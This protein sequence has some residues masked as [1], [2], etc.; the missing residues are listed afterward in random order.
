MRVHL[1]P[2]RIKPRVVPFPAW[3]CP[4]ITPALLIPPTAVLSAPGTL[5]VVN[6]KVNF[7]ALA[8]L[9]AI[10]NVSANPG[11]RNSNLQVFMIFPVS[12]R[13]VC[14]KSGSDFTPVLPVSDRAKWFPRRIRID[15]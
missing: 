14:S 9:G 4:T 13:P 15:L 6:V 5:T 10:M 3:Y 1:S 8:A 7:G 2:S 11:P 12:K